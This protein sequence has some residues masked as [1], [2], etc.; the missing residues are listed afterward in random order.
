MAWHCIRRGSFPTIKCTLHSFSV[1]CTCSSHMKLVL[2]LSFISKTVC[3][4]F[5]FTVI[6]TDGEIYT[7]QHMFLYESS[8]KNK[9]YKL[10]KRRFHCMYPRVQIPAYQRFSNR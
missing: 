9:C 1:I 6:N 2:F 8:V 10:C 3:F 4:V 5:P 7:E